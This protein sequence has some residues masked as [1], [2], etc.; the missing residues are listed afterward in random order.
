MTTTDMKITLGNDN[1]NRHIQ[2]GWECPKCSAV[3]APWQ[4]CCVNCGGNNWIPTITWNDG[5]TGTPNFNKY[6]VTCNS[7]NITK[8]NEHDVLKSALS[9]NLQKF[10]TPTFDKRKNF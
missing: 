1:N 8:T 10:G 9:A 2:Q 4:N 3:M 6:E 5:N 7:T